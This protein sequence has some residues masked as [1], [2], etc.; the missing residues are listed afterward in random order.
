MR[1]SSDAGNLAHVCH[2]SLRHDNRFAATPLFATHRI[3]K[4]SAVQSS[5][6]TLP[7]IVHAPLGIQNHL[8]VAGEVPSESS[9]AASIFRS[10]VLRHSKQPANQKMA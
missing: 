7:T 9:A 10:V 8:Q 5:T 1:E 4:T 3:G 2:L 6:T